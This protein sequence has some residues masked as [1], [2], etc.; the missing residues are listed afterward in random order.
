M[1]KSLFKRSLLWKS[2]KK[3]S[4]Y[5]RLFDPSGFYKYKQELMFYTHL[6]KKHSSK[7]QLIFDIGANMG[8][9]SFF[10]SKVSKQVIAF[11][12][13]Q[14]LFN[15][16]SNRFA[17]SNVKVLQYALGSETGRKDFFIT[18]S[19]QAYNSLSKKHI[20]TTAINRGV[21]KGEITTAKAETR[22]LDFFINNYGI[23]KY[24]KIDVEGYEEEVIKGL[25]LPVPIISFEANLPDF[26]DETIRILDY[27]NEISSGNYF[28]NFS[29]ENL[30]ISDNFLSDSELKNILKN[31]A[32]GY[33]EI[34]AVMKE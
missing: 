11:E 34:F 23:P 8:R 4:L 33:I 18:E 15:F 16:L 6:L 29:S 25:K 20:K 26:Y 5:F 19:N 27:L 31:K 28:Y 13:S 3:S 7:N 22:T 30:F 1:I 21:A 24:I 2:I 12:P 17:G 10:F 32:L 14:R 9:K